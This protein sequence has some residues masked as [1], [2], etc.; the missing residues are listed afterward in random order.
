MISVSEESSRT[1]DQ[2]WFMR[3]IFQSQIGMCYK[4]GNVL[5]MWYCAVNITIYLLQIWQC[6]VD[7]IMCYKHGNLPQRT[8]QKFCTADLVSTKNQQMDLKPK[9]F[10]SPYNLLFNITAI[11]SEAFSYWSMSLLMPVAYHSGSFLMA[12]HFGV[13]HFLVLLINRLFQL[14]D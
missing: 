7:V 9:K 6:A 2:V 8:L 12:Y 1:F 14:I 13:H 10:Y 3:W 11:L 5:K 4:P